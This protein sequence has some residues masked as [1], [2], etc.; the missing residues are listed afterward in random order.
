MNRST[1]MFRGIESTVW[2]DADGT[3]LRE[4]GP[5]GLVAVRESAERATGEGWGDGSLVDLMDAVA[6]PV[7]VPLADPRRLGRLR[8]RVAGLGDLR[9]PDDA[10]QRLAGAEL[11]V[12]RESLDDAGSFEP[13]TARRTRSSGRCAS[14]RAAPGP[15]GSGRSRSCGPS[16]RAGRTG[17]SA[18]SDGRPR[19]S[20]RPA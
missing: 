12:E 14:A 1:W 5:M 15:S 20:A 9:L 6:V 16:S 18:R 3:M 8:L 7:E 10:R 13:S 2:L 19:A 17:C 4:E 11:V